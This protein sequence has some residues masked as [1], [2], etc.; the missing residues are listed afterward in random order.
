MLCAQGTLGIITELSLR[1]W[2]QPEAVSA[3]VCTFKE[4]QVGVFGGNGPVF[5][6]LALSA[7]RLGGIASWSQSH[8]GREMYPAQWHL[9][10]VMFSS[11]GC[12]N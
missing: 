1:L 5:G 4:M 3:A 11:H 8:I 12:L 6:R 2:G 7:G 10:L 9:L